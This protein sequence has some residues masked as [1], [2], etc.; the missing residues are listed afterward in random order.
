MEADGKGQATTLSSVN[1]VK[2]EAHIS[3]VSRK[4]KLSTCT[5]RRQA[6]H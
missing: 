2:R 4:G 5:V 3:H 6:C 1:I